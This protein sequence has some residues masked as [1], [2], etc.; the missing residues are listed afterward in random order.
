MSKAQMYDAASTILSQ[1]VS[2]VDGV[3]QVFV[4]GGSLPA[5]RVELDPGPM[6]S[7]GIGLDDVAAVIQTTSV[8]QPK[9]Q[10][11]NGSE[12]LEIQCNDQLHKA[13]EYRPIIVR[14]SNGAPVRLSDLG[15]CGGFGPGCA[16]G[17]FGKRQA[18]GNAGHFPVAGGQHYRDGGPDPRQ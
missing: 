3:G 11:A 6:N 17:G 18:G 5:V 13:E 7:Y 14:Y 8:S 15:D 4:G 16:G 9:G 2:Q 1:K 10:L 12:T